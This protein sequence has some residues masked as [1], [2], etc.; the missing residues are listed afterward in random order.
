MRPRVVSEYP[1]PHVSQYALETEPGI[2]SVVYRLSETV[3]QSR[4]PKQSNRALLYVA[5]D[6]SDAELRAEPLVREQSREEPSATVYSCD[7]RGLG[8]SRPNTCGE[9]T[10]DTPYGCDYFYAAH[11]IMLDRSYVGRRTHDVLS[12]LDWL[13][14]IG[15]EEVH[16]LA[17]GYGAI[18][19]AF[20]AACSMAASRK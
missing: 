11:G 20:A 12:V 19:A 13:A 9:N 18:P 17:L 7:V 3:H 15:H 16:L 10:Y 6:S 8:E 5:H 2:I 4:P 1:L 14:E